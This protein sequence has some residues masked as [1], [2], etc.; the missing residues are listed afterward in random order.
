MI[1]YAK[2]SG[3]KAVSYKGSIED[4]QVEI[5]QAR[6][7]ILYL[8]IGYKIF[9][10]GHYIVVVGYNKEGILAHSGKDKEVFMRYDKLLKS[11]GKTG[12]WTLLILPK[13]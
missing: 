10:E 13:E 9:P 11:W 6:P 1:N 12:F 7:L 3:F 2:K 4:I 5:D 8:D